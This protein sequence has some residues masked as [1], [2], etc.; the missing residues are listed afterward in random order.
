MLDETPLAVSVG[1]AATSAVVHV[2]AGAARRAEAG[3]RLSARAGA[4]VRASAPG[5]AHRGKAGSWTEGKVISIVQFQIQFQF[6]VVPDPVG[7]RML[8]ARGPGPTAVAPGAT[9]AAVPGCPG[10]AAPEPAAA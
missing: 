5:D 4:V 7:A 8:T 10:S 3:L 9:G 2:E 1:G 6:H